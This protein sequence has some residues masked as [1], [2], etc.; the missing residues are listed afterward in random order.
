MTDD[1]K[2]KISQLRISRGR[3]LLERYDAARQHAL[4]AERTLAAVNRAIGTSQQPGVH[5][6]L[7][8]T[9]QPRSVRSDFTAKNEVKSAYDTLVAW[10]KEPDE[11]GRESTSTRRSADDPTLRLLFARR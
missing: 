3:E 5:A 6:T 2:A 7:V 9:D 10:V 4:V 8:G 1:L 11:E